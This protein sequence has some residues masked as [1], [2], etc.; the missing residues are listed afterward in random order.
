MTRSDAEV[1]VVAKIR[2]A[3]RCSIASRV[4]L[5]NAATRALRE[6]VADVCNEPV[7]ALQIVEID[8]VVP[9]GYNPN[10][11]AAPELAL[12]EDSIRA[13]GVTMPVVVIGD[14]AERVEVI[15]GFHR[16]GVIRKL[17]RRYIPCT[18][19]DRPLAD[20]MASTIRHNRARGKHQVDLMGD[21]VKALL[22]QGWT[23]PKIAEHLGMSE[24]E[25]LRLKQ[26][27]GCARLLAAKEYPG[28]WERPNV[29][30][31]ARE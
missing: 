27:V 9:N 5:Y 12:L 19:I 10:R 31:P 21:L 4:G 18:V 22:E 11:V 13:D 14:P 15:D 1:A 3:A 7:L 8:R 24:E 2:E 25:L 20:R 28:A 29:P 6:L 17:G 26:M 16:Q 23:D 30:D